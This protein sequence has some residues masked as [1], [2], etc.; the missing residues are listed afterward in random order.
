MAADAVA[1]ARRR[2]IPRITDLRT[3]MALAA[4]FYHGDLHYQ[5]L[6][7]GLPAPWTVTLQQTQGCYRLFAP[8]FC[9][10]ICS[11]TDVPT[12]GVTISLVFSVRDPCQCC[13]AKSRLHI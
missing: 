3:A 9:A 6:R 4:E 2:L 7:I 10:I 11:W 13:S 5:E 8:S 12:F 1:A